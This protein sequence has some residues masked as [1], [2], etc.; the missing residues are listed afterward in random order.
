MHAAGAAELTATGSGCYHQKVSASAGGG[1]QKNVARIQRQELKHD[2]F[3]DSVEAFE[4]YLEDNWRL[5]AVLFLG[6]L[7][8]G[9]S[10]GGFYWYSARQEGLAGAALANAQMTLEAQVQE[11]LPPL[12]GEG[13]QRT[14]TSERAKYEAAEKEFAA[15]RADYPRTRAALM[16][17]HYEALCRYRLG[18]T[19]AALG[20]LAELSRAADPNVAA[21]AKFHLAGYYED[22][23]KPKEAEK[24]YRQLLEH[25]AATVPR[26]MA[27]LALADLMAPTNPAEARQ[28]YNQVKSEFP[29]TAVASEVSRRLELLPATARP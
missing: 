27:L 28:L 8:T 24:L 6:V 2:E 21:L 19:E 25:P 29:D 11:G 15:I 13:A 23:G 4:L 9:G 3:I 10:L 22:L 26:A 20:T 5:L 17:K 12:P 18:Q 7:L 1:N 16:A 14:F